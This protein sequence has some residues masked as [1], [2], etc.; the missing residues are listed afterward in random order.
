VLFTSVIDPEPINPRPQ[1]AIIGC[2]FDTMIISRSKGQNG[3]QN[4]SKR[5]NTGII[6]YSWQLNE[7]C[8]EMLYLPVH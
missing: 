2:K 3:H 1:F 8:V 6:G 5:V 7:F 4:K